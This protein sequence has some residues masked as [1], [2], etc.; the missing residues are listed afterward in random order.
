MTKFETDLH[1]SASE[2]RFETRAFIDGKFV[3]AQSGKT[4][5]TIN[6]AT[7]QVLARVAE[8]DAADIDRAVTAARAAFEKGSWSKMAP[9]ERKKVLLKFADL[10]E[11]N[12][13]EL[14]VME[15]LDCGKP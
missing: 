2:L 13:T 1:K 3:D 14:A 9:R 12:L 4:F 7:G 15:T 5:E 6:P 10:I 11:K 8:G